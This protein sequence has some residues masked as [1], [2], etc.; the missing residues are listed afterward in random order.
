M[1]QIIECVERGVKLLDERRPGWW[2]EIDL[3]TFRMHECAAC[4]CGQLYGDW[5]IVAF[6][7]LFDTESF[8]LGS[9]LSR[10]YGFSIPLNRSESAWEE[11]QDAWET[12][13]ITRR[14]IEASCP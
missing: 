12:V 3:H 7:E 11:L 1:S 9:H 10:D 14:E 5:D 4:V 2:K 6:K 8:T 13:I